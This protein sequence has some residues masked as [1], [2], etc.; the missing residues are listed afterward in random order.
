M[1]A[2]AMVT[3]CRQALQWRAPPGGRSDDNRDD[4]RDDRAQPSWPDRRRA[5][6]ALVGSCLLP[7]AG[8]QGS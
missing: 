6:C 3:R 5:L 4:N 1:A 2:D 8:A 7:P